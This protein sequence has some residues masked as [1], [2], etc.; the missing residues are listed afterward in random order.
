MWAVCSQNWLQWPNVV[1]KKVGGQVQM[2][3][4]SIFLVRKGR[5][6]SKVKVESREKPRLRMSKN[7]DI[8]QEALGDM[9]NIEILVLNWDRQYQ[10][11]AV[12]EWEVSEMCVWAIELQNSPASKSSPTRSEGSLERY[13]ER[14]SKC[15]SVFCK[16]EDGSRSFL[17][18]GSVLPPSTQIQWNWTCRSKGKGHIGKLC[19]GN[20]ERWAPRW[21][22]SK[23]A[24][25]LDDSAKVGRELFMFRKAFCRHVMRQ[26][27]TFYWRERNANLQQLLKDLSYGWCSRLPALPLLYKVHWKRNSSS[28]HLKTCADVYEE[29]VALAIKTRLEAQEHF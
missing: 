17:T 8:W 25:D 27:L 10:R 1:A 19:A 2:T 18:P 22:D 21:T 13:S 29:M 24:F 14:N 28:H 11:R 5:Y 26:F 7:D 9:I 15:A 6:D 20:A 16:T 12:R 4:S 3:F 23:Q